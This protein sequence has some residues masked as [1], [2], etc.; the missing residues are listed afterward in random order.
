MNKTPA[1]ILRAR[2]KFYELRIEEMEKK[3][4]RDMLTNA[5]VVNGTSPATIQAVREVFAV[6]VKNNNKE[7]KNMVQ[8]LLEESEKPKIPSRPL[9]RMMKERR[10]KNARARV[11][12]HEE[13]SKG[14]AI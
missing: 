11:D 2:I 3:K 4:F 7:I 10:A 8:K 12:A 9:E 13:N 5:V 6:N 14:L 1:D